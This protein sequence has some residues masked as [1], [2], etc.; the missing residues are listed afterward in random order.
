MATCL[1]R[2]WSFGFQCVSF[3]NGYRYL[4]LG[5]DSW[6]WDLI[7]FVSDHCLSFFSFGIVDDTSFNSLKLTSTLMPINNPIF[8]HDRAFK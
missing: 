6:K 2:R 5:F 4:Y 1:G 8:E 3:V 7:G